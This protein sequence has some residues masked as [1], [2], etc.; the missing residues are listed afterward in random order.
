MMVKDTLFAMYQTGSH[1]NVLQGV[2][3][4]DFKK[5]QYI[6]TMDNGSAIKRTDYWCTKQFWS[7]QGH[8]T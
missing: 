1:L 5:P 6:H 2:D 3:V 8:Y 7:S 4:H